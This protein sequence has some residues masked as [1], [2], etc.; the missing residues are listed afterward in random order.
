MESQFDFLHCGR[1][2]NVEVGIVIIGEEGVGKE[3]R[4]DWLFLLVWMEF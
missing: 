3:G 1:G 2:G 4:G